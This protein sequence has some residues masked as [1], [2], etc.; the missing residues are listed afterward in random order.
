MGRATQGVKVMN[1][2]DDDLVSAV[3][4]VVES[5]ADV[6]DE[7]E[8][9]AEAAAEGAKPAPE[10]DGSGLGRLERG[11]HARS[12]QPASATLASGP[13]LRRSWANAVT[14][15]SAGTPSWNAR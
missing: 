3:A 4:L 13:S 14:P 11:D 9:V 6:A 15:S 2:K 10:P 12:G 5:S 8:E 7:A 1:I